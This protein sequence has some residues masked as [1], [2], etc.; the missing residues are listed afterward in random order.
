MFNISSSILITMVKSGSYIP[1]SS[2]N[3]KYEDNFQLWCYR[4][5]FL[6][7]I[8]STSASLVKSFFRDGAQEL[9]FRL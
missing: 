8:W 9:T 5:L 3:E 2:L 1:E 4:C 7:V 6:P